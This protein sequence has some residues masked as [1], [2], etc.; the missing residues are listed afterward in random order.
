[1]SKSGLK[2]FFKEHFKFWRIVKSNLSLKVEN[3]EIL[4]CPSSIF[5]ETFRTGVIK[6]SMLF[7]KLTKTI[8]R[9]LEAMY[10]EAQKL[11]NLERE[12]EE[13]PY[14]EKNRKEKKEVK[15]AK[16]KICTRVR[17]VQIPFI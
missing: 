4:G 8:P 15:D 2:T 11:I 6:N 7:I 3:L 5:I 14:V 12:L 16:P 10:L 13:K 1:M 9:S 17:H